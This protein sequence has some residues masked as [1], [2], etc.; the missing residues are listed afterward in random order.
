[1]KPNPNYL[2]KNSSLIES[3]YP[4]TN[5]NLVEIFNKLDIK[6]KDVLTVLASSDQLFS[7]YYYG[8]DTV[9]T[10]DRSYSTLH[11]YYL[12]KWLIEYKNIYELINISVR[13]IYTLL[14][15]IKPKNIR[16]KEAKSFWLK[17]FKK[18][19]FKLGPLFEIFSYEGTIPYSNNIDKI[20]PYLNDDINFYNIDISKKID[21]DISKKYDIIYLSNLTEYIEAGKKR[22][23]IR[24]N[25]EN[26][27]KDDGIAVATYKMYNHNDEWHVRE[28]YELTTGKLKQDKTYKY[29]KPH[30]GK[31][32]LFYTYKKER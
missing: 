15:E 14:K 25:L 32:D 16:E 8:A 22:N 21:I 24:I 17:Y 1:M 10:F 9:D 3:V 4:E 27:L 12:R 23:N 7:F 2:A 28:S 18:T 31:T 20:K 11:Y 6:D 19:N 30:V 13:N 26:L 29:M 5:E